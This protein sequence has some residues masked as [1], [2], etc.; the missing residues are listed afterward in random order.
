MRWR[1]KLKM[2]DA[3]VVKEAEAVLEGTVR[4]ST[5]ADWQRRPPWV[6]VNQL[7]HADGATLARLA[8]DQT[9]LHPASWDYACAILASEIL[10][11]ASG[12]RLVDI[13]RALV[14]LELDLLAVGYTS[15]LTPGIL[16]RLATQRLAA[17]GFNRTDR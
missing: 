4:T 1:K 2:T 15:K 14:P 7:A 16:V 11:L 9:A 12:R 3:S 13:Q 6:Y 17:R 8:R 10:E 5:C